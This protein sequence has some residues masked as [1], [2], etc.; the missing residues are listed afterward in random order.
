MLLALW[1]LLLLSAMVIGWALTINSGLIVSSSATTFTKLKQWRL[2]EPGG[3]NSRSAAELSS[4]H[5]KLGKL[6]SDDRRVWPP[7]FEFPC[8][9]RGS[10]ETRNFA[11]LS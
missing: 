9:G 7:E 11:A 5:R 6:T 4:L 3:F 2:R 1:A 8:A 10:Q